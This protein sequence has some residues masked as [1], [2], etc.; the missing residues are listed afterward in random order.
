MQENEVVIREMSTEI[1]I[2][3]AA[4]V[5]ITAIFFFESEAYSQDAREVTG[6]MDSAIS[7]QRS[8]LLGLKK[9]DR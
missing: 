5:F 6:K 9:A 3:F 7:D 1:K 2:A 8:A 4:I